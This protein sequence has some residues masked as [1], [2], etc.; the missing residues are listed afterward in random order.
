MLVGVKK[1]ISCVDSYYYIKKLLTGLMFLN[2]ANKRLTMQSLYLIKSAPS[3]QSAKG[4]GA[5]FLFP[6]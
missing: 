5:N 1:S 4:E 3:S 2:K 6:Y